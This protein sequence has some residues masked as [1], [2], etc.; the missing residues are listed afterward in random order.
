VKKQKLDPAL[1][2]LARAYARAA[3]DE[4]LD[5]SRRNNTKEATRGV[6]TRNSRARRRA[7]RQAR[8]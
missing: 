6:E 7:V 1:L 2:K 5:Q 3:V 4:L 8:Q